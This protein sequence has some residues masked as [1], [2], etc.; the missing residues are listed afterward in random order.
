MRTIPVNTMLTNLTYLVGVDSF[1]TAETNAAVRSFNRFGRLAWERARWPDMV[2]FEQKIPDIQVRNVRIGTGGSGYTSAPT[3]VFAG[4]GGTG[5]AATAT[6][7]ADGEVNGAAVTN[8]GT[9]YTSPPT[10]SF[11]G[12][13]GS[14][15]VATATTIATLDYGSTIGEVLR[16]TENDPY[17]TGNTRDLAYRVEYAGTGNGKLVLVDRSSTAP[18]YVL[19]RAPFA[20]YSAGDDFPYIFSEYATLGA[21]SDHLAT[22]G[23]FEK[24]GLIQA[25]AE[26][27]L[28]SELDKLERAQGQSQHTEFITYGTTSQIGI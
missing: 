24:S 25:Q 18:V 15:A 7:N 21:Y 26:A 28:L 27:V 13:A 3:I 9:G 14:G 12:G 20:D 1:V 19:Y 22:D 8:S 6:I 11:T 4:G 23:Q 5:A 16:I 17:E 2:R 10:I